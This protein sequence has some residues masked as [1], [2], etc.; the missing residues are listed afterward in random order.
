MKFK[1]DENL[2]ADLAAD[3][4]LAG[5]EADTVPDE[6]LCD[7]ADSIIV[8][9]AFREDRILLMLDKGIANLIRHPTHTHAG[10]VL[11]RPGAY[12]RS[13]VLDFIRSHLA[14]LL[15]LELA[16]RVTVVSEGRIRIR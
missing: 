5:H 15:T 8:A 11:F 7:A 9:A 6:N 16:N 3:L 13:A 4:H 14:E 10:V 2:P 12:G 1:V